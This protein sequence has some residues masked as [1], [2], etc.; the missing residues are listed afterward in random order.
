MRKYV[1]LVICIMLAVTVVVHNRP[2]PEAVQPIS[3][4]PEVPSQPVVPP[5]PPAV[6]EPV[7]VVE[8]ANELGRVP[9]LMYHRIVAEEGE[10]ARSIEN[11]RSDLENLYMRG[12]TLVNLS[13]FYGGEA[14]IPPGRSPV[15][16]TFDDA[17]RG[18]FNYLLDDSG[19]PY[20]D[21]D[22]AVGMLL[23]AYERWPELGLAGT[24]FLNG[25]PFGQSAYW[26]DK[27]KHLV[28][29]GFE[30]GSHTYSHPFFN[31]VTDDEIRADIVKLQL[32]VW[33]AVPEYQI[34]ALALP[35]GIAPKDRS[36][37]VS[38]S[39]DGTV[40]RHSYLMEVGSDPAFAPEHVRHNPH[41][42]PRMAATDELLTRWLDWL[43]GPLRRYISDGNPDVLTYPDEMREQRK[44]TP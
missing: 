22:C 23:E 11:F 14:Q 36:V 21:P 42:M 2:L 44:K 43:D 5:D 41:S 28:E 4:T 30:L 9:I 38:G 6:N 25:N 35:Y 13:D 12:Y 20:I 18:Q 31:R 39:H 15:I 19:A 3:Q 16:L 33:Q 40:F 8:N 29:L 32:Q 37:A 10:W 1:I 24:F 26:Q 7:P 27:L 17:T 34:R